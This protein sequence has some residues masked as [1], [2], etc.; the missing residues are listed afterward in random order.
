MSWEWVVE[1]SRHLAFVLRWELFEVV[2]VYSRRFLELPLMKIAV[3]R[4]LLQGKYNTQ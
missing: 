1:R 2:V 4:R 3:R